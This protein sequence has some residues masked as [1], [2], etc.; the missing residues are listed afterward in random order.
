VFV[1]GSCEV[2]APQDNA[3]DESAARGPQSPYG[4]GKLKAMEFAERARVQGGLYAVTGILF[5]HESPRRGESFVTRKISRAAVRISRKEQERLTL[6]RLDVRRDWGFAGDYVRAMWLMMFQE[7][8]EDLVI[9]TGQAHSVADFC[10]IA[11]LRVG[12]DWREHVDSDPSMFRPSD[13]PLRLAN[14]ARAKSRL[15]WTPEVDFQRLVEMMID[16]ELQG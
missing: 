4:E 13:A 1:A 5:N 3:Q 15:G 10:E 11:F 16:H 2:F 12:L 14:P 7:E 8:P 9:G 6:G